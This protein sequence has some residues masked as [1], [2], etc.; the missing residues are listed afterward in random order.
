MNRQRL[1]KHFIFL[2][3]LSFLLSG[4][5]R[6]NPDSGFKSI[7][8]LE[9]EAHNKD[10]VVRDS[11]LKVQNIKP[12]PLRTLINISLMIIIVIILI[13]AIA[14]ILIIRKTYKAKNRIDR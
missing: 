14:V 2:L 8:Q 13:A 3:I 1:F 12:A 10:T 7:H 5:A 9:S 4:S 6:P 11:G